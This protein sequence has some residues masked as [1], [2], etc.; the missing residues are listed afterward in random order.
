MTSD[1]DIISFVN[2]WGSRDELVPYDWREDAVI[3]LA[4]VTAR[5][6][7]QPPRHWDYRNGTAADYDRAT[8]GHMWLIGRLHLQDHP[9]VPCLPPVSIST[10]KSS[11]S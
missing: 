2:P 9:C 6:A 7:H 1:I 8:A 4:D 3:G 10:I 11:R 5:G